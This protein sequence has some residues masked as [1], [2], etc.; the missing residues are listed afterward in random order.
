[1]NVLFFCNAV[2]EIIHIPVDFSSIQVGINTASAGDTVLVDPGMYVENINF[3]GNNI[4]VASLYLTTQ[5]TSYISETIIDGNQNGSVVTFEN[6]EDSTAVLCGFTLINGSTVFGGGICCKYSS[7]P[8]LE[9]VIIS[10][11]NAS[12]SGGGIYCK[13]SSSPCLMM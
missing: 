8:R 5:D 10:D 3:I 11:N 9:N 1:M 12:H 7:S 13:Y 2:A 6:G 4:T